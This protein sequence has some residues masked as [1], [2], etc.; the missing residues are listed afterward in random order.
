L[1][2]FCAVLH[3]PIAASRML[4][5]ALH[6]AARRQPRALCEGALLPL[7][8]QPT[9]TPAQA[10]AIS[11]LVK[12]LVA[13]ASTASS[14]SSSSSSSAAPSAAG[15]GAEDRSA[16]AVSELP[17]R[18]LAGILQAPVA[19]IGAARPAASSQT[20]WP[21]DANAPIVWNEQLLQVFA[22]IIAL[23]IGPSAAAASSSSSSSKSSSLLLNADLMARCV[24]RLEQ[25][26]QP[27]A[28]GG[29][30]L[31]ASP[32]LAQAVLALVSPQ[33]P[34]AALAAAHRRRWLQLAAQLK[35]IMARAIAQHANAMPD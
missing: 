20:R 35:S 2:F 16:A 23:P 1:Y 21:V 30:T 11:R 3:Q 5:T 6:S 25:C 29:G 26:V 33:A 27:A 19:A 28:G 15:G 17:R 7:L 4:M 13:P 24:E 10:E 34:H 9:V 31:A 8:T 18:L 14:S 22:S 32:R 12:E